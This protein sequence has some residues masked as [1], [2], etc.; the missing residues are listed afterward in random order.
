MLT[1]GLNSTELMSSALSHNHTDLL[2][3]ARQSVL[4]PELPKRLAEVPT[5]P[6][7]S[8]FPYVDVG[9]QTT[10]PFPYSLE[11]SLTTFLDALLGVIPEAF[12]PEIPSLI[13][14]GTETARFSVL[15]R[16]LARGQEKTY[17][18]GEGLAINVRFWWYLAPGPW[19][20]GLLLAL[21]ALVAV[22][23]AFAF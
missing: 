19:Q 10:L 6:L 22:I 20:S 18:T 13:G 11:R 16:V 21:V 7:K 4:Q 15:L 23:V 3:V 12:K 9:P 5:D 2:G 1:G 17:Y 14:A 8:I